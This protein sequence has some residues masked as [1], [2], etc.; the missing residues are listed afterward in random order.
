M[1][2]RRYIDNNPLIKR[3]INNIL[4]LGQNKGWTK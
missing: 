1:Y 4:N 3:F 2:L